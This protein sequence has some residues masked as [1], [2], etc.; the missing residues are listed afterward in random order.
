V[1]STHDEASNRQVSS[2][3]I[4]WAGVL[5]FVGMMALAYY[6]NVTLVQ[7]GLTDLGRRRLGL[8]PE[9]VAAAMAVLAVATSAV[10]LATGIYLRRTGSGRD[11]LCKL[12]LAAVVVVVQ[13]VLTAATPLVVSPAAYLAWL[14]VA[15]LALGVGVPATF[16]L[17]VDLVRVRWRGGAAAAITAAAY[18]AAPLGTGDW[19]IEHF[20]G[21]LLVVMVPGAVAAVILAWRGGSLVRAWSRQH[22]RPEYALGRYTRSPHGTGAPRRPHGRLI[23]ALV[24][25]FGVFFIDSLGF[26]RLLETPV[27]MANAWHAADLGPRLTIAVTHVLAALIGGV[28]YRSLGERHLLTWVFGVFALVHLMY[29]IDARVGGSGETLMTPLLYAVAVSLYTV[30]TFA[31]W[32]D[33]STP[34]TITVHAAL[35]VAL[36]AWT[37]TFLPTALALRW[38]AAGVS[39]REHLASVEA[40][41]LLGFAG[42]LLLALA[43]RRRATETT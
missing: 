6:Y 10:A 11:M 16:G 24:L 26:L 14:L 35:G 7:I 27:Y 12:R 40:I 8:A 13:T 41:A 4:A 33:L 38:E 36:S 23:G 42:L 18:F 31:L 9:E 25:V 39:L 37:A 43:P 2:E 5:V 30:V 20:T 34:D 21:Q 19:T 22:L 1:A 15:S 3:P 32:A 17:T 29:G 28:L